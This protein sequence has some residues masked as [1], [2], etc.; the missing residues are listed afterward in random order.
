MDDFYAR[1]FLCEDD[2]QQTEAASQAGADFPAVT[3]SLTQSV[4]CC[5]KWLVFITAQVC[6][7]PFYYICKMK[8]KQAA[9]PQVLTLLLGK[10]EVDPLWPLINV[11][12]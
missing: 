10:N 3:P 6:K 8:R 1:V 4:Y 5:G 9:F 7:G 2:A 12:N 11:L